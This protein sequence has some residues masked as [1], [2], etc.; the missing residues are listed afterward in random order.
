MPEATLN[1]IAD[2]GEI[3][4]DAVSRS[5]VEAQPGA[6]RAS[7]RSGVDYVEVTEKLE[8]EGLSKFVASWDDLTETVAGAL[9]AAA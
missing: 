8:A 4:G 9:R 7:R 1:A 2:H 5:Y 6:Q 3:R